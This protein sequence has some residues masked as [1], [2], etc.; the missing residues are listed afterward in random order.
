[1]YAITYT[2]FFYLALLILVFLKLLEVISWGWLH[3]LLGFTG[4]TYL[5]GGLVMLIFWLQERRK[6]KGRKDGSPPEDAG[7][8]RV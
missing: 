5:G 1:M 2:L 7:R 3:L 4:V 6:D 8:A